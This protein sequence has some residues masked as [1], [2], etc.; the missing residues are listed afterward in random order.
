MDA[1]GPG[2]QR[3]AKGAA[4]AQPWFGGG[5]AL[6]FGQAWGYTFTLAPEL[7]RSVSDQGEVYVFLGAGVAGTYSYYWGRGWRR[8]HVPSQTKWA[9]EAGI[10]YRH[11][12]SRRVGMSFQVTYAHMAFDPSVDVGDGRVGLVVRF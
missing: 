10:G 1:P 11:F 9:G 2:R 6:Y 12:F 4:E 3:C 8:I 5:K 7:R